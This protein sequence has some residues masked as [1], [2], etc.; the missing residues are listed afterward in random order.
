MSHQQGSEIPQDQVAVPK[1]RWRVWAQRIVLGLLVFVILCFGA[2]VLLLNSPSF[3]NWAVSRTTAFLSEKLETTVTLGR[4]DLDIWQRL[5]LEDL[6][7]EDADGDILLETRALKVGFESPLLTLL[8][9]SLELNSITLEHADLFLRRDTSMDGNNLGVLINRLVPRDTGYRAPEIKDPVELSISLQELRLIDVTL[10]DWNQAKGNTLQLGVDDGLLSFY[11]VDPA[12]KT[13][14][15]RDILL[16]GL[17]VRVAERHGQITVEEYDRREQEKLVL[18]EYVDLD[19]YYL[20]DSLYKPFRLTSDH[21]HITNGAFSFDAFRRSAQRRF[22]A[23]QLDLDHMRV[24]AIDFEIDSFAMEDLDFSG[25]VDHLTFRDSSGFVAEHISASEVHVNST[26]AHLYG[27]DLV[28][29]YSR[30]GDTLIFTYDDYPAFTDFENEVT[31]DGHFK[32]CRVALR[33]IMAFA[34]PLERNPFFSQNQEEQVL[35]NGRIRGTVNRLSSSNLDLRIGSQTSLNSS[36]NIRD[37]TNPDLTFFYFD[38]NDFRSRVSTLRQLLP[39]AEQSTQFDKLGKIRFSGNAAGFYYDFAASGSLMT[40]AGVA[41]VDMQLNTESGKNEATYRGALSLE[42]FDLGRLAG[43][44][45]L[46]K[47]TV[48]STVE[49]GRGLTPASAYADLKASVE[50]FTFKG[51]RYEN[52]ELIGLLNRDFFKGFFRIENDDIDLDFRGSIEQL[53]TVPRFDM[54]LRV[55]QFDLYALN[56]SKKPLSVSG[57]FDIDLLGKELSKLYGRADVQDLKLSSD[58]DTFFLENVAAMS[59]L[60]ADSVQR[61]ELKAGIGEV[62][63]EGHFDLALLPT[64]LLRQLSRNHP[65]WYRKVRLPMQDTILIPTDIQFELEIENTGNLTRVFKLP[66]EPLTHTRLNGYFSN[67]P[68]ADS[69]AVFLTLPQFS[70]NELSLDDLRMTITS[71][72]SLMVIDRL[73]VEQLKFGNTIE[74]G[75]ALDGTLNENRLDFHVEGSDLSHIFRNLSISGKATVNGDTLDLEFEEEGLSLLDKGWELQPDNLLRIGPDFLETRN[76]VFTHEDRSVTIQSIRRTG[77]DVRFSNFSLKLIDDLWDYKPLDFFGEFTATFRVQDVFEMSGIQVAVGADPFLINTDNWGALT[78]QAQAP[79]LRSPVQAFLNIADPA[80]EKQLTVE[81]SYYPANIRDDSYTPNTFGFDVA[82][83]NYPLRYLEYFIGE[84]VTDTEGQFDAN[85]RFS[86]P[87]SQPDVEGTVQVSRS[88]LTVNYLQTRYTIEPHTVIVDN[89][90]FDGTGVQIRDELGNVAV[91]QGGLV[92]NHLKDLGLDIRIVADQFLSLDTKKGDNSLFYGKAIGQIDVAFKGPLDKLDLNIYGKSLRGTS[93]NIPFSSTRET[94]ELSFI[95]FVDG[96]ADSLARLEDMVQAKGLNI[97][98]NLD[99]TDDA[100]IS[101]IFDEKSGDIIRGRGNGNLRMEVT[102]TGDFSM[103]GDY[104]ISQGKYLF[105]LYDL[106]NKPFEVKPGGRISWSG[107]PYEARIQIDAKYSGLSTSLSNFLSS[108]LETAP[109]ELR[110]EAGQPTNVDVILHLNGEL[111]K[112]DISFDIEFPRLIGDLRSYAESRLNALKQDP[113]E[114]NYQVFG[115]IV[116]NSFLPEQSNALLNS[117]YATGINTVSELL[118]NQL[119]RYLTELVAEVFTDVSFISGVDF[120]LAY[121]YFE[122]TDLTNI[123]NSYIGNEFQFNSSLRLIE[124]K[125]VLRLGGNYSQTR[126]DGLV[127]NEFFTYDV[128]LELVLTQDRRYKLR[129]YHRTEPEFAGGLQTRTGIGLVYRH[130]FDSFEEL[131]AGIRS[132]EKAITFK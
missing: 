115:L 65:Q 63:A 119:S 62:Y 129:F 127:N 19:L 43:D 76:L 28:T 8:G 52:I 39:G 98:L 32:N 37:V 22:R 120:D 82:M 33:D 79:D 45:N 92:H 18:P 12:Q 89:F 91:A 122:N 68:G 17:F 107:D 81:G 78:L 40:E 117:Q 31:M 42:N 57:R 114:M 67:L 54:E 48:T 46:G 58:S 113:N 103:F 104:E 20:A 94:E 51:Y 38:V 66:M 131:I 35:L 3:Q 87:P 16:D 74:Y 130:Q 23:D 75:I 116:T 84:L 71:S 27:L 73:S 124:D 13:V 26:R 108:V 56:L 11:T 90:L 80:D 49:N 61:F 15:C 110:R 101:L 86:G 14:R 34:I 6:Y 60:S 105:T 85:L 41:R 59:E 29:P 50:D 1:S 44:E 111:L 125:V 70:I 132:A 118:A 83:D 121:N 77:L 25:Q 5:I 126:S 123:E 2:L 69:L 102:R 4:I 24:H 9:G 72:D 112:P 93:I 128:V 95:R 36:F 97:F 109:Q 55:D 88:E 96:K 7:I 10:V 100:D 106:V 53:S 47:I 21:I 64:I 99:V 30:V